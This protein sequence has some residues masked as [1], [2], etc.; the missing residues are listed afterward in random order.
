MLRY[1]GVGCCC[2]CNI[3]GLQPITS[4]CML[5]AQ[6]QRAG[7]RPELQTLFPAMYVEHMQRDHCNAVPRSLQLGACALYAGQPCS[8]RVE[9]ATAQPSGQARTAPHRTL[10][11]ATAGPTPQ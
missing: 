4:I 5:L 6:L 7:R 10:S 1:L 2:C 11:N 3:L 9:L 8:P